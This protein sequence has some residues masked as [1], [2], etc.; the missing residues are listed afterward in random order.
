MSTRRILICDFDSGGELAGDLRC[1]GYSVDE[2][3]VDDLRSVHVGDHDLY[4][5]TFR[6]EAQLP[7]LL[8]MTEK[9]KAAQLKTPM[10]LVSIEKAPTDFLKHSETKYRADAYLEMKENSSAEILDLAENFLGLSEVQLSNPYA[11]RKTND[12]D[13]KL[14]Q[15]KVQE[16]EGELNQLRQEASSLDKALETQRNFYKPK[17]KALFEGQKLQ[18]QSETEQLKFKLSEVE[19]KL[20]EREAR[21]KELEQ[22]QANQD[23]KLKRIESS[24][25]KAQESLRSFY[26]RK[27]AE[28]Q[29]TR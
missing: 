7:S 12:E 26:Q 27:L 2:V 21:I 15:A 4:V 23:Q 24:H 17:L 20:L 8:K 19:A 9:L 29:K 14:Y 22:S 25:R 18:V 10:V 28:N 5:F 11:S 3:K 1:V 6:Q 16:L 13:A